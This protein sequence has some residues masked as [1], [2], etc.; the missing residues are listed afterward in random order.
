MFSLRCSEASFPFMVGKYVSIFV[1]VALTHLL[2]G[3]QKDLFVL[4]IFSVLQDIQKQF[5]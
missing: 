4:F 2:L 3:G 1:M 5:T